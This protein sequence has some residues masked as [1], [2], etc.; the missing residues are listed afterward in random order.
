MAE[1]QMVIDGKM[2]SW[3][4][5][6]TC[7]RTCTQSG[8]RS[9]AELLQVNSFSGAWFDGLGTNKSKEGKPLKFGLLVG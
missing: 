4:D 3:G 1:L 5:Y 9:G 8:E 7:S 6:G 2:G